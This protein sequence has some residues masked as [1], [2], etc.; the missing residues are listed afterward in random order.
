MLSLVFRRMEFCDLVQF[1]GTSFHKLV[2]M[3]AD[4]LNKE[5][6]LRATLMWADQ[7][8]VRPR[9]SANVSQQVA[10]Q[11]CLVSW[12]Q[13]NVCS[14]MLYHFHNTVFYAVSSHTRTA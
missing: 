10:L 4:I 8:G 6:A 3:K 2:L 14:L 11:T 12:N 9:F 1:K 7:D 13:F 5:I